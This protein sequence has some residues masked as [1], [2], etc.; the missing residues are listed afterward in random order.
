M[1]M[2]VAIYLLYLVGEAVQVSTSLTTSENPG[3]T[4][5]FKVLEILQNCPI[6]IAEFFRIS[7]IFQK[8]MLII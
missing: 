1:D 8:Q 4:K 3:S 7:N 5:I 6:F 2:E